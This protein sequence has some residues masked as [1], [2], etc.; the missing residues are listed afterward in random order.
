MSTNFPIETERL[1]LRPLSEDDLDAWADFLADPEATRLLHAPDPV[2]DPEQLEAGLRRWTSMYEE[3]I[4]MYS[5]VLPAL[6]ETA[7]FVGFMPR[8]MAWGR[9]LELGWLLRRRFWGNGYA[10]EAARAV[11]PLTRGR[12][13]S[14]IR[15]ENE[16]SANVARKLGMTIEREIEY[17]GFATHVWAN[18]AR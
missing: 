16:P 18:P 7:G 9:E 14:L 15:V 12:V 1:W 3:P 13:I 10:T 2:N 4:G 17:R 11:R 6:A 8:E 5:V